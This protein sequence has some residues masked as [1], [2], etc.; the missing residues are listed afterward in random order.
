M[1]VLKAN[2]N[3]NRKEAPINAARN[4]DRFARD[5]NLGISSALGGI[6]LSI[7][8]HKIRF[9]ISMSLIVD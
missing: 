4:P 5:M 7:N 2:Q 8:S 3:Q 9:A 6:Y 1:P